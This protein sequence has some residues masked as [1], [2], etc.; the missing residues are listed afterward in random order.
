[1]NYFKF[2]VLSLIMFICCSIEAD[3]SVRPPP[4]S[5][6]RMVSE[7]SAMMHV[8]LA[9]GFILD[10]PYSPN[11][12]ELIIQ[13]E[14]HYIGSRPKHG[15]NYAELFP[16]VE[17]IKFFATAFKHLDFESL[18]ELKYLKELQFTGCSEILNEEQMLQFSYLDKLE[19]IVFHRPIDQELNI[20]L[21]QILPN[22][23]IQINEYIPP[24]P[25]RDNPWD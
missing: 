21:Q 18:S 22:T 16:N 20:Q 2:V 23:H 11:V 8:Q 15:I 10:L 9:K 14:S 19:R 5:S 7:N 24:K 3:Y 1:M 4:D 13:T 12:K 17:T 25:T 6:F